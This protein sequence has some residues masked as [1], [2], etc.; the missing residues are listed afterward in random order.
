MKKYLFILLIILFSCSPSFATIYYGCAA[1]EITAANTFKV[2][3]AC[4]GASLTWASL[5]NGDILVA[6]NQT[7]SIANDI[8]SSSVTVT[9]TTDGD[10][11]GASGTDGGGFTFAVN[12]VAAKTLYVNLVA[13]TTDC[14]TVSGTGASGTELTI[15]GNI[16]GG[17]GTSVDGITVSHTTGTLV[18][19]GNITGG[20]AVSAHGLNHSSNSGIVEITG[21][22]TGGSAGAPVYGCMQCST[23]GAMTVTGNAVGG[24]AGEGVSTAHATNFTIN[25]DCIGAAS[26]VRAGCLTAGS[27]TVTLNGNMVNTTAAVG[28]TGAINWNPGTLYT[29]FRYVKMWNGGTDYK[30]AVIA[31]NAEDVET[32]VEYGWDGSDHLT[33]TLSGGGGGAWAQ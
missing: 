30:Y 13:G 7:I 22:C 4:T 25:G 32:G 27:G 3:A 9:L 19:Q 17:S 14:L 21:N 2:D 31:P 8:G 15:I 6:N 16:T 5:A 29:N 28:A 12:A 33:G 11:G 24:A 26:S 23:C 20:S 1:Q 18:I 10:Y